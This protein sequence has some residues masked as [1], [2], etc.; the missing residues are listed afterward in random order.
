MNREPLVLRLCL[1]LLSVCAPL[2]PAASREDWRREWEAE[3]RH[4]WGR[5]D[6]GQQLDWR[7]CMDLIRRALGALP[8][9]AWLRRQFTADAD[10]LHDLRHGLRMLWKAPS[11]TVSAVLILAIGIGGTIALVTLLD[12]LFFRPLP[13]DEA[14]RIVTIWT[15]TTAQPGEREDVAPADFLDWRERSRSFSA[16]AAAIPFSY[17]YTGGGEPEVLFGAQVT[18]GFWDAL[19]MRPLLGRAFLPGAH[20]RGGRKSVIITYGLWQSRFAGDPGILNRAIDLDG[21]PWTVVGVLPRG[22][23]PQLLPGPGEL[24]VWTPKIIQEHDARVRG[25]AWWSVIARLAPGVTV[26]QAQSEMDA[27]STALA[28]EHPRVNTGRSAWVVSMRD[29][30]MGDVRL[31]LF[32]MLAAVLLVLGIGCANVASLLLARGMERER[33]FAIRAALGA[34]RFRLV[35]QLVAESLLLSGIAAVVGLGLAYWALQAIVALA[36]AGVLRLQDAAIDGR[37]VAFAAALTTLTAVAFG[38]IPAL[39]FSSRAR[40]AM[41]ERQS[42]GP[43]AHLRRGLVAAE[44][45]FALVLLTGAGLLIRSFE[46]LMSVDPG[47]SAENVVAVQV[48]AWDRNATAERVLNFFN[49]TLDR[50]RAIPGVQQAGAVSAMPF[51]TAN[52]DIKSGLEIPGRPAPPPGEQRSVYVTI[53]TPGYFTA[54]SIPL[55]EGRFLEERD[56]AGSPRAAVI[57]EGLRRREWPD[58]SPIGRRIKVSWQGRPLEAEVVG[59]VS[60]IRHERLD[61]AA[62]PE[63]F[64]PLAQV[65]FAS[66]T[67]VLRGAGEPRALVDAARRAI[68]TVDPLQTVYDSAVVEALIDASVVRERFS[69]TLM[70]VFAFVALLLCATGIYGIISFTTA[71]RTREIG[72]RMALGAD[73]RAIQRM[74]LREGSSVILLGLALG[75]AGALAAA[76]YVQSLLFETEPGDPAT[77]TVVCSILAI[78]GLA[79]CYVPARRATRVDPLIALRQE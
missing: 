22:F 1:G 37:I 35:R 15:R 74:V 12:T 59:V 68:W 33:E 39:Q 28:G 58:E 10:A 13:Y 77:F 71:Q 70:S 19:G 20:L 4:R 69:M 17:D 36:P 63:I 34:G 57:S 79:A 51:A 75:L 21:E 45:A 26:E 66:M 30:L 73:G 56:A 72:V 32:V 61:V 5:L 29:H 41:R 53:A 64:L 31:P 16:V 67:Y 24:S 48:F 50:M 8:D 38:L 14:D 11:F 40:D 23:A 25:S 65:P 43:R 49:S 76:R 6:A 27:I 44:I 54:M 2:V 60:Q 9:A 18:E 52:I 55:R 7:S 46:R 62:R 78:V 47:F 42:S 3:V